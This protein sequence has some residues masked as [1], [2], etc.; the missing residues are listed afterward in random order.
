MR[1]VKGTGLIRD[2]RNFTFTILFSLLIIF[3]VSLLIQQVLT[4]AS[5]KNFIY[6]NNLDVQSELIKDE[7]LNVSDM[8]NHYTET[9]HDKN[10]LLDYLR[11]IRFG[12]NNDKYIFVNTYD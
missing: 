9:N 4:I 10:E 11:N 3:S 12:I 1:Q 2:I 5:T 8:V 6:K 7:I